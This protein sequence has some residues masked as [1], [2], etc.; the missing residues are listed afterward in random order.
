[1][2]TD[3]IHDDIGESVPLFTTLTLPNK[4]LRLVS[5]TNSHHDLQK[6]ELRTCSLGGP[7]VSGP[8]HSIPVTATN[9]LDCWTWCLSNHCRMGGCQ[10]RNLRVFP[11]PNMIHCST[12]PDLRRLFGAALNHGLRRCCMNFV[13]LSAVV[14]VAM[15]CNSGGWFVPVR[16]YRNKS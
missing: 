1:M 9:L 10:A 6:T 7:E 14:C 12:L 2:L 5:Y 13:R 15:Q 8:A 3:Q 11:I 16:R 4:Q